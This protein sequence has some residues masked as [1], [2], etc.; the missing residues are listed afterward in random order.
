MPKLKFKNR[1]KMNLE[2]LFQDLEVDYT[3]FVENETEAEREGYMTLP[4][5]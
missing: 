1:P 2:P 3:Y 5:R 4:N